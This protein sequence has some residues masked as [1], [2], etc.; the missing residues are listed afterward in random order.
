VAGWVENFGYPIDADA[1]NPFSIWTPCTSPVQTAQGMVNLPG[2][3][4]RIGQ[5]PPLIVILSER[6]ERRISASSAAEGEILRYAQNDKKAAAT[7][8]RRTHAPTL[9]ENEL[10]RAV[11]GS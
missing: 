4:E 11:G 8:W 7:F 2:C 6:S 1:M 9:S 5:R 10:T 3:A